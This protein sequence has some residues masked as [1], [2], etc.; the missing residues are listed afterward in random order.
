MRSAASTSLCISAE[1]ACSVLNR[2]WLE[3]LL[4]RLELR[5]DEPCFKLKG[6]HRAFARF[7]VVDQAHR[8]ASAMA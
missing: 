8:S 2:K 7:A 3:L 4:Q 5:L 6:A 1:I